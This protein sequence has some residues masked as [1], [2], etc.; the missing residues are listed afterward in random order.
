MKYIKKYTG[1]SNKVILKNGQ[2]ISQITKTVVRVPTIPDVNA[3]EENFQKLCQYVKTL[4]GIDTIHVLPYHTYGENKYGLL[5]K[6][7]EMKETRSL[8]PEEIDTFK[9]IIESN[10]FKCVIGG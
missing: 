2:R 3:T 4:N 5:G 6:D 9:G 7:Y 8:T 10:G 1:V